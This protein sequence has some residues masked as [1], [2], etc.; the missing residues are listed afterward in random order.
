MR[1]RGAFPNWPAAGANA[2]VLNHSPMVGLPRLMGAPVRSGR[3]VPLTPCDTSVNSPNT[4][5]E[6][7][8]P[9]P[10]VKS[11]L[12]TQSPNRFFIAPGPFRYFL[13]VPKGSS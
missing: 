1:L 10:I 4:R 11:P 8:N 5:G 2:A 13:P 6:N 9:E 3:D 7:G 12:H